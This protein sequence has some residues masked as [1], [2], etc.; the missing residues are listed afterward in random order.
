MMST[1]HIAG[2]N[3]GFTLTE[4]MVS[5][6]IMTIL[7]A[8][9][10]T[11]WQT[12]L[13][14]WQR[15]SEVLATQQEGRIVLEM[16]AREVRRARAD[17]V[18]IVLDGGSGRRALQF[19]V[20]EGEVAQAR[21]SYLQDGANLIR[22]KNNGDGAGTNVYL[23]KLTPQNGFSVAF[24]NLRTGSERM[25]IGSRLAE[26]EVIELKLC[27]RRIT[28]DYAAQTRVRPRN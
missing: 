26:N 15:E 18:E 24:V 4:L 20:Y 25:D 5:F 8:A 16:V 10:V 1:D 21:I 13:G 9:L 2:N 7:L 11:L 3:R 22:R 27:C 19:L 23:T 6:G 28:D 14:L 17:S 12:G